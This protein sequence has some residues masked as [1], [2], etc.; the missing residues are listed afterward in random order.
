[1]SSE[2]F[3]IDR[4][5]GGVIPTGDDKC[6][7]DASILERVVKELVKEKLNDE[8][9]SMAEIATTDS[10]HGICPTFVV[11]TS[12]VSGEGPA[13]LFRSYESTEEDS[14]ECPIWQAARATTAAPSFFKPMFVSTPPPGAWYVD[15][16][17]RHNNPSQL[18]LHEAHSIWP[19][20][21]RF[22]LVSIGTG[23]RQNVE[24]VKY[25]STSLFSSLF[26]WVPGS[27]TVR[28]FNEVK[29]IAKATIAMSTSSE[30]VH[31]AVH[32][33]ATSPDPDQCFPYHRFNVV[34]GMDSI[35]LEEWKA[36]VRIGML[37]QDYMR[38]DESKKKRKDCVKDLIAL[39]AVE[40]M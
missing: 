15:G 2:I 11:A 4:V 38:T 40:R 12:G 31:D 13:V 25:E 5:I 19:E 29:N 22:C 39:A 18:A 36:N 7:F 6:R 35:D 16:G 8:N 26:H 1:L 28:G 20:I 37:T 32:R 24:L 14:D 30:P 3:N 10:G 33:L 17:L 27:R 9:A 34:S 23:R 21:N